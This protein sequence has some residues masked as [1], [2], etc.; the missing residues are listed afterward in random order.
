MTDAELHATQV[1]LGREIPT[2]QSLLDAVKRERRRRKRLRSKTAAVTRQAGAHVEQ[3]D[4][5]GM[6]AAGVSP[7]STG[8]RA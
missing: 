8:A 3:L 6:P 4:L 2:A 1:R 5:V 7:L